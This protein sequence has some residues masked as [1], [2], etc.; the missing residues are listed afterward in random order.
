MANA[1]VIAVDAMGGD[2]Y[3][4]NPVR[5]ALLA[6]RELSGDFEL[7][8][9]GSQE[10]LERELGRHK[11]NGDSRLRVQNATQIVSPTEHPGEVARSKLDSSIHVGARLVSA[12]SADALV[13]AGNTGALMAVSLL[14]LKRIKGVQRPA[15]AATFP[16][17]LGRP[18]LVLDV[19]ANAECKPVYL[20]QFALMGASYSQLVLGQSDPR[21]GLI[22]VGIEGGKG[23]AL[24]QATHQLLCQLA[25]GGAFIFSGNIEGDAILSG[26]CQVIVTD[27]FTGNV[28]LKMVE[29][30]KPT[31]EKM[32]KRVIRNGRA[33]QMVWGVLASKVFLGPTLGALKRTFDYQKYGGAPFLGVNGVVIKAHGR[34][35]PEAFKYAIEAAIHAAQNNMVDVITRQM[36]PYANGST[37]ETAGGS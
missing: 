34:S 29:G 8:L 12:G 14:Q 32:L 3:P 9:V 1:I 7:V 18:S 33:D 21:V 16:T 25:E 5:G 15:L 19:G 20:A 36:A 10:A 26:E 37:T 28:V 2:Y 17:V 13:S 24:A 30:L 35:T 4:A 23:N 31:A 27:G 22:N 11:H 6:L